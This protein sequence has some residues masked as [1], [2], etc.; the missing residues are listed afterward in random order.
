[1]SNDPRL[2]EARRWLGEDLSL[3]I[4][5]LEPA[6]AD[7]SFR[8][9]FRAGLDHG[10]TRIL[11]DAPPGKEDLGAYLRVSALLESCGVHVPHVH[12]ADTRLGFA[13]LEDLGGTHM[14]TGLAAGLDPAR[15]YRD[16]LVALAG[17]QLNG[18]AASMQLPPYDQAVLRREMQLMPEWF[19]TRHLGM[20]LSASQQ[21]MLQDSFAFLEQE[22]LAQPRV[23]VHRD[24]HSRNLMLVPER[25]PGVIDFQDAL[26]G[27]V[28][29]DLVSIL[30]DCYVAWPRARVEDWVD[31]FRALLQAGGDHGRRLAGSSRAGFLRGF[32]AIG[33][34]RHIK[35]LGIFARLCW[36][37]GKPGY[38][39]DLPRTLDYVRDA[40]QRFA[41]LA[42]LAAF[43]ETQLVLRLDG[44][45]QR[46]LA[47]AERSRDG[48]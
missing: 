44:A 43:V 38:L 15:L 29:Y 27:P 10:A 8:R 9:Y 36:R 2:S 30:K 21:Q 13:L 48:A 12:A 37:D 22:A 33:L 25:S 4:A 23:F 40:V 6:S 39:G 18:D 35:V 47:A 32:D 42:P 46:A 1:M 45:N 5:S 34:Q 14:L 11:M 19:C 31:E 26:R 41:E 24:Y 17:L 7:A 3:S 20:A 28:G 16:A